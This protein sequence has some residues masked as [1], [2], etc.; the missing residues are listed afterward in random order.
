MKSPLKPMLLPSLRTRAPIR[1]LTPLSPLK[2][3]KCWRPLRGGEQGT[4]CWDG[5]TFVGCALRCEGQ[6]T[7]GLRTAVGVRALGGFTPD[8][9]AEAE[10]KRIKS[11]GELRSAREAARPAVRYP[12]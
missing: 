4:D 5:R 2:S 10:W 12:D 11:R 1:R 8:D 6:F 9:H 3:R 7:K